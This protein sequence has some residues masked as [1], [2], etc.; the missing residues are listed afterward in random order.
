M[1]TIGIIIVIT[2][3]LAIGAI[4]SWRSKNIL[5]TIGVSV[6]FVLISWIALPLYVALPEGA[7]IY[8]VWYSLTFDWYKI[9]GNVYI[10]AGTAAVAVVLYWIDR[11]ASDGKAGVK[12]AREINRAYMTFMRNA[13]RIYMI[14][15]DLDFLKEPLYQEQRKI[16]ERLGSKCSMLCE[17]TNDPELLSLYHTLSKKGIRIR[18]YTSDDCITNLTGQIKED[19]KGKMEAIFVSKHSQKKFIQTD[20]VNEFLVWPVFEHYSDLFEIAK[21]AM[22]RYIALDIGGVFFD[23]ELYRDFFEKVESLYHVKILREK[24]DK[25]NIDP[26]IMRGEITIVK[27]LSEKTGKIFS[28]TEAEQILSIWN[29]VWHPNPDIRNLMIQLKKSGYVICPFA[30][31]DRENGD[32]YLLRND[33]YEFSDRYYFSYETQYIK[34][35]KN[36]FSN[37]YRKEKEINPKLEPFQILLIDDQDKNINAAAQLG[38]KT[39]KFSIEREA[40]GAL[41]EK[42]KKAGVF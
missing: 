42:L 27:Y 35:D 33:F 15:R 34:P 22:I 37:F 25:L 10:F 24:N 16:A 14:G 39:V 9:G 20:L 3:T 17:Y 26:R 13:K 18:C 7:S 11:I 23:G 28:D 36:A 21:D 4:L 41:R 31:L 8:N 1:N 38:W 29:E 32:M 19:D 12:N 40:A 5:Q 30:N 2:V 6:S